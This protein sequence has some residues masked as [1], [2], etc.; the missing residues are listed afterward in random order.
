MI[1]HTDPKIDKYLN[2]MVKVTNKRG[3]ATITGR[4]GY[5]PELK[6]YIVVDEEYTAHLPK[7]QIGKIEEIYR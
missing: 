3:T 6:R 1:D 5:N 4:L 2:K 7:S